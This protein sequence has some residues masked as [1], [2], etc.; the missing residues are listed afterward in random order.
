METSRSRTSP[1]DGILSVGA[2][3][4]TK[5]PATDRFGAIWRP[6]RGR[7]R[8]R[9]ESM[10]FIERSDP[11]HLRGS[12]RRRNDTAVRDRL[13]W[14]RGGKPVSK[15]CRV[16]C[17]TP[18]RE[19]RPGGGESA[20]PAGE[21]P[22]LLCRSVDGVC[23]DSGKLGWPHGR[24]C[25]SGCGGAAGQGDRPPGSSTSLP[26]GQRAVSHWTTSDS[27][28]IASHSSAT[29][30]TSRLLET[31]VDYRELSAA[32]TKAPRILVGNT[33]ARLGLRERRG[34]DSNPR[35]A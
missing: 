24:R 27:G 8:V 15:S 26:E 35:S 10:E 28:I 9:G 12:S 22:P 20:V 29:P 11:I 7:V 3:T 34:R 2:C 17:S 18:C 33:L 30:R 21:A 23:S 32:V 31:I 6:G 19:T 1:A 5:S 13:V 14:L 16:T 4:R 25:R